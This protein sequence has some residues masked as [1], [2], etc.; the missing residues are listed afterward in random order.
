ML[1]AF[2]ALKLLI[3]KETPE[4]VT[5]FALAKKET[6]SLVLIRE[7]CYLLGCHI[8]DLPAGLPDEGESAQAATEREL[9]GTRCMRIARIPRI[10]G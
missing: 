6:V 1:R 4:G 2:L 10:S 7:Y 5:I 8:Y 3:E 9:R